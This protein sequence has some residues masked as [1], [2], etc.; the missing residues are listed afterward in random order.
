MAALLSPNLA[1]GGPGKDREPVR[2]ER[3]FFRER[4]WRTRHI[5]SSVGYNMLPLGLA[6][7]M[8]HPSFGVIGGEFN[9]I[10][11]RVL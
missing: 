6:V 4:M 3:V 7:C 2:L 1:E 10:K 5:T 8:V 11:F 9:G